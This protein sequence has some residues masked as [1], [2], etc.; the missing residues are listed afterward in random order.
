MG[1][2]VAV[3]GVVFSQ[4]SGRFNTAEDRLPRPDVACLLRVSVRQIA[5]P[6][7]AKTEIA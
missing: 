6:F 4:G 7:F 1:L 2:Y 5:F 3:H